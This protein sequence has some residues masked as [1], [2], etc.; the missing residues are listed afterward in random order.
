MKH[1]ILFFSTTLIIFIMNTFLV[2]QD[3]TL[4]VTENGKVGIGTTTPSV[5]LDVQG[6]INFSGRLL[7]NG[8]LFGTSNFWVQ[9]ENNIYYNNGNVSIGTTIS[10]GKLHVASNSGWQGIFERASSSVNSPASIFGYKARGTLENKMALLNGD[11]IATFDGLG[12][13]GNNYKSSAIIRSFVD[14][15]V[16]EGNV[17]G[18]FEFYTRR[19]EDADL[20]TRVVIKNDGKVGIGILNPVH[21]LEMA[22]GAHVTVA[23]VWSNA[24]SRKL[25]ENIQDLTNDE[26]AQA[27]M[28]LVPKKYNYKIDK[29]EEYL[30]FIAEEVPGIVANN[31]RTS[32]SPMDIVA[33]LTKVVQQQQKKIAELEERINTAH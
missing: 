4:V 6:D 17:P 18:R 13:D 31:D 20:S 2:G 19:A 26:A 8:T 22:S 11:A 30:G 27:L 25:K 15:D 33:L 9:T 1:P 5:K 32:L 3:T 21:P 24:S 14:G 23:G 10:E 16:T 28:Q 29:S 7:K 12:Y